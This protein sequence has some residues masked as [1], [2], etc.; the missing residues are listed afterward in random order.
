M[1]KPLV[2]FTR[3]DQTTAADLEL[4]RVAEAEYRQGTAGRLLELFRRCDAVDFAHPVS[5]M[6][7][8][9]QTAS[10]ALRA[11]ADEEMVV[12]ALLHDVGEAIAPDNHAEVTA[13]LLRPFISE[14]NYWLLHHH[15][16]FQ[17]YYYAHLVGGDRNA[18][19]RYR[20]HPCFARTAAFC[21]D[22]DQRSFD[23]AY[24]HLPLE[25]FEPMVRRVLGRTPQS[26]WEATP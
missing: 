6:R 14:E 20:D 13:G 1:S 17:G 7:H 16:L 26:R 15:A 11:G 4:I 8:G 2:S 12:V 23:P 18:R 22:W 9:L 21:E 5:S 24:E 10:R 19:D 25:T 3:M